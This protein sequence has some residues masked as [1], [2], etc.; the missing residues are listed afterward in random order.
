MAALG[1]WRG[2]GRVSV[3]TSFF[4]RSVGRRVTSEA[5]PEVYCLKAALA[6]GRAKEWRGL[7]GEA[8]LPVGSLRSGLE[9]TRD[10][11]GHG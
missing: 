10:Y 2:R 9:M 6:Q 1:P 4:P 11:W 8:W 5:E 3:R 7:F